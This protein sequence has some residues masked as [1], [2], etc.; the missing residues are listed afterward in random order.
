MEVASTTKP[1][2]VKK[3]NSVKGDYN[4][5]LLGQGGVG[6]SGNLL[7]SFSYENGIL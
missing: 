6:K 3:M 5:V 1:P 7:N 4:I 2:H